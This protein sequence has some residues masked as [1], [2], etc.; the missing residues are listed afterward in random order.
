MRGDVNRLIPTYGLRRA[1]DPPLRPGNTWETGRR[2]LMGAVKMTTKNLRKQT[3]GNCQ[4]IQLI[5]QLPVVCWA[6]LFTSAYRQAF[7][8]FL[9]TPQK[10]YLEQQHFFLGIA[11]SM[12]MMMRWAFLA[13]SGPPGGGW[14]AVFEL[15]RNALQLDLRALIGFHWTRFRGRRLALASVRGGF[16]YFLSL[17]FERRFNVWADFFSIHSRGIERVERALKKILRT[18]W[19]GKFFFPVNPRWID[20]MGG[21]FS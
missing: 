11:P 17:S 12:M 19:H 13:S 7:A 4:K 20:W 5:W 18:T 10:N 15:F 8:S 14:V 3:T 21:P 2:D 9:Q 16:Q 6:K 1:G